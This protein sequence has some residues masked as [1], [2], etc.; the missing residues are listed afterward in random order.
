MSL[1]V[2]HLAV[3]V[4]DLDRAERFYVGVL[5]LPVVRRWTD[6]AGQ[7]RS[8]WVEIGGAFLAIERAH[9]AGPVRAG[10]APGWHCVALA[11]TAA[12]RQTWTGRLAASAIPIE[13][14]SD[15]SIYFRDPDNNLIALSHHP[16]LR[17]YPER[18]TI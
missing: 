15:Y 2:H 6:D 14:E 1:A 8:V 9:A 4:A 16:E 17:M 5:G 18:A 7:P 12:E 3:V 10:E 11:I 13:R